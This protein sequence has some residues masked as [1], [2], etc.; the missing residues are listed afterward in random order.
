LIS[1][2][3]HILQLE[4]EATA[5]D[6]VDGGTPVMLA[7]CKR[8]VILD[9]GA[10][11]SSTEIEPCSLVSQSELLPSATAVRVPAKRSLS[12]FTDADLEDKLLLRTPSGALGP[13]ACS[14]ATST[15][16]QKRSHHIAK[17]KGLR[18]SGLDEALFGGDDA[19]P[20]IPMRT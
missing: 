3:G 9:G 1:M 2:S 8:R 16:G 5:R 12:F 14:R 19:P 20:S 7:H 6:V 11:P 15:V 18:Y 17:A 10:L 13:R 4:P